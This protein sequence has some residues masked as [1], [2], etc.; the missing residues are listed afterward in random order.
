[1]LPSSRNLHWHCNHAQFPI[2][3]KIT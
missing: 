1:M 3:H 2:C